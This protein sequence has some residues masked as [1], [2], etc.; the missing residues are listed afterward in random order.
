M[1]SLAEKTSTLGYENAMHL[2]RRTTFKPSKAL[3]NT[4]ASLTPAQALDQLF[5][6]T[7]PSMTKP[8]RKEDGTQYFPDFNNTGIVYDVAYDG[9]SPYE[10]IHYW[11]YNSIKDNSIQWKLSL[12]L[13]SM[14]IVTYSSSSYTYDYMSLLNSYSNKSI[15]ELA[16]KMTL[17]P[18]MLA[19]LSNNSNT[20]N[21]PNQNYAREFLELFTILKGPQIADGNYT[22]YTELDVQQAAKVL[23]GFRYI[24]GGALRMNY[25]DKGIT[26]NTAGNIPN[27]NNAGWTYATTNIP[28][29]YC[30]LNIHDI[31]NKTF[32][33]A[34]GGTT[35]TGSNALTGSYTVYD[36]L[37]AFINMI[38]NQQE[39]AN[40]YARRIYRFFVKS[41]ITDEVEADIIAPLA[42]HLSSLQNGVTYNLET[43][44]K[45][46]LKSKHF[47]DEDDSIAQDEVI[48][49]KVKSPFDLMLNTIGETNMTMPH[50]VTNS[51]HFFNFF[52]NLRSRV[53]TSGFQLFNSVD[54][55]GYPGYSDGPRYDKN[56]VT[57]A[58]LNQ[59]Y[60]IGW[61][62][63]YLNGYNNSSYITRLDSPEFIRSSGN[64]SNPASP[65]VL[66]DELFDIFFANT[67]QGLRYGYFENA[68]LNGLSVANWATTW[69]AWIADLTNT[70]K[71]TAVRTAI[72]RLLKAIFRSTEYQVM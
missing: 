36:E 23:S 62:E 50:P 9:V 35:I 14:F 69:N 40:N 67:P 68:L 19:Y 17:N 1:A 15:K 7:T 72:D 37:Q 49:A 60:Y 61:I 8:V 25:L 18:L 65:S 5:T 46:L 16:Y 13:H 57:I 59:R 4:F 71:K 12:L 31:T 32:S 21:S 2:L 56:W 34:F 38:F 54:V 24:V 48:G 47:Y 53:W 64:F 43:T 11:A 26:A 51:M 41:E 70:T 30:Q 44:V 52:N 55:S 39:T 29:G 6:F 42:T 45:L 33:S 10:M 58:T 3:A 66:L 63:T 27:P 28:T 20:K 22:N